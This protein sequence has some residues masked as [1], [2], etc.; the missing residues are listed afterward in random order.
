MA[1]PAHRLL[2]AINAQGPTIGNI[3]RIRST[4]V[5]L[6]ALLSLPSL[7]G[8]SLIQQ[9]LN[10]G[11]PVSGPDATP[12]SNYAPLYVQRIGTFTPDA[13][14]AAVQIT[15]IDVSDPSTAR[16]YIHVVDSNGTYLSGAAKGD[17]RSWWCEIREEIGSISRPLSDYTLREVTEAD[18]QPHAIALVMDHSGSM[19][20]TRARAVQSAANKLIDSKKSE[21]AMTFV[22]YDG[23]VLVEVPLTS[24]PSMLHNGLGLD[25][26]DGFGGMTAIG[27]GIS[28]GIDQVK[29]SGAARKAVIIFTDGLDNSSTIPRETVI[30]NAKRAG[31][32]VCAV[33]FG[34]NTNPDYLK[35]VAEATGGSY[36]K[37]YRTSE[38]DLVFEDIYRRLRNYYLLEYRPTEYGV[39]RLSAK[40]CLEKDTVTTFTSYN[41]TPDIGTVALLNVFF[42][43]AKSNIKAESKP[44]IDNVYSLMRTFPTMT[45]ELRGHTDSDNSTGDPDYNVKLSQARADAVREEL[46]RRGISG[47]RITALGFGESQPIAENTTPEGKA[48]NRR[49]EFVITSR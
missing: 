8:C 35:A 3:M 46:I 34:E 42:D 43:V 47:D 17:W 9:L 39:H 36:Y 41:N 2:P 26:L 24:D 15:R 27:D 25:G 20:E 37:I 10:K 6:L 31:V 1:G 30:E 48:K 45:I 49:T 13:T 7:T 29:T 22:K 14:D 11:E 12:P 16:A 38:F 32:I 18:R 21:D 44:A 23:D 4:F 5:C 28:A 19:G 40:L 33:D